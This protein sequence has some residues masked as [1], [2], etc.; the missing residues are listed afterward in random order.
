MLEKPK[1]CSEKWSDLV[2]M[3][4]GSKCLKC[5]KILKDFTKNSFSEVEEIQSSENGPHC[6]IYSKSQIKYWNQDKPSGPFSIGK[7]RITRIAML[8]SLLF[9]L[10]PMKGSTEMVIPLS[11]SHNGSS[12]LEKMP[13]P[14]AEN[15]VHQDSSIVIEG[16]VIDSLTKEPLIGVTLYLDALKTGAMTDEQGKFRIIID[17]SLKASVPLKLRVRYVGHYPKDFELTNDIEK[18]WIIELKPDYP[19]IEVFY[20]HIPSAPKRFWWRIKR[21][22]RLKNRS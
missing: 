22:F 5:Q 6:G 2:P 1:Y 18:E 15:K 16:I 21:V 10:N 13:I 17:D 19:P 4:G 3:E 11:E 14:V 9:S 8:S 7:K 20:I 12:L